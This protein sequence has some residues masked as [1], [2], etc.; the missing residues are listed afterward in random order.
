METARKLQHV[1]VQNPE[2]QRP[3]GNP[4]R[5][6][7]SNIIFN[8]KKINF[9][10]LYWVRPAQFRVFCFAALNTGGDSEGDIFEQLS[11][12]CCLQ[13]GCVVWFSYLVR[14]FL[15]KEILMSECIHII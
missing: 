14:P 2:W 13:D 3:F 4:K 1:L 10:N 8:L 5:R 11:D 6:G 12:C 15:N 7:E 9:G